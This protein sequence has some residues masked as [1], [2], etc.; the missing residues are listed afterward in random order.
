ME[1]NGFPSISE[2]AQQNGAININPSDFNET[3]EYRMAESSPN[4]LPVEEQQQA[5]ETHEQVSTSVL[6]SLQSKGYDVSGYENDEQLIADTEA[7]Y[8][9]AEQSIGQAE[10]YR[11]Q[12]ER[13]AA[14]QQQNNAHLE[15]YQS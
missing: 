14:M 15:D 10:E 9:A 1:D 5:P 6:E 3:P 2:S 12:I 11:N 13:N 7:R 4:G 8:A